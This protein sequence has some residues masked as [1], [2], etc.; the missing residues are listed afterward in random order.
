MFESTLST[1][2]H[3][4]SMSEDISKEIQQM[5]AQKDSEISGLKS[6]VKSLEDRLAN[7]FKEF[8]FTSIDNIQ[9][10]WALFD[11]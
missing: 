8:T 3:L 9:Q 11:D 7:L 10:N 5:N 4:V 2:T 1:N 6:K